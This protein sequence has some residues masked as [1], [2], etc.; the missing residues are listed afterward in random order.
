[1]VR[2]V[3]LEDGIAGPEIGKAYQGWVG[4]AC[5][6]FNI[7]VR[8]GG[9]LWDGKPVASPGRHGL[10]I[11]PVDHPD[12]FEMQRYAAFRHNTLVDGGDM[13]VDGQAA[14]AGGTFYLYNLVTSSANYADFRNNGLYCVAAN[15]NQA[16]GSW[17]PGTYSWLHCD[18]NYYAISPKKPH[19]FHYPDIAE[20]GGFARWQSKGRDKHGASGSY[21]TYANDAY[22]LG[23]W[24]AANGKGS[25]EAAMRA[26]MKARPPSTWG[27]F[28]DGVKAYAGFRAAYTPTSTSVPAA[29][30][31]A[32]GFYGAVDYR[33]RR[34]GDSP[35]SRPATGL[36]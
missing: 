1:M 18:Y 4:Q 6:D 25:T 22:D 32:L 20:P 16:S 15:F 35:K 12:H 13:S 7:I 14:V 11:S 2:S 34:N 10:Y 27:D 21:P 24:A 17:D 9:F 36:P 29:G 33:R 8:A 26:A 30:D 31:S 3:F 23:S 28:Y 19:G 5:V